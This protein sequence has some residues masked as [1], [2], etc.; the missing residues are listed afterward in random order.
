MTSLITRIGTTLEV[1]SGSRPWTDRMASSL[2]VRAFWGW[3]W[4]TLLVL[5][6]LF[7]R[8]NSKFV[9]IDF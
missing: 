1:L 8:G 3:W 2:A 7:S 5:V 6:L 4:A 9:Y